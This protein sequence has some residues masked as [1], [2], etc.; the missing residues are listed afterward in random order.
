MIMIPRVFMVVLATLFL[1][2]CM[3]LTFYEEPSSEQETLVIGRILFDCQNTQPGG[4][5]IGEYTYNV[6]LAFEDMDTGRVLESSSGDKGFFYIRNPKGLR[7]RL[8]GLAYEQIGAETEG[9]TEEE[10]ERSMEMLAIAVFQPVNPSVFEIRRNKVNNLGLIVWEGDMS[11]DTHTIT[12][13]LEYEETLATFMDRYPES[14][15]IQKRWVE[16]WL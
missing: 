16:I 11:M 3:S 12:T 4:V 7:L 15:W 5:P 14:L 8:I 1:M 10:L 2:S 9:Y 13:S 6:E